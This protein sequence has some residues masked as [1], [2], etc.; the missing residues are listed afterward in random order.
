MEEQWRDII[1]EGQIIS[2][3][4]VSNRGEIVSTKYNEPRILK[5]GITLKGYAQ[6]SLRNGD[7]YQ[8]CLVHR[9][10]AEA[11]VPNPHK[12][13]LVDHIDTD[14]TNN[15]ANNLRWATNRTNMQNRKARKEGRTTSKFVGVHQVAKTG[16]WVAKVCFAYKNFNLG[17]FDTEEEAAAR[18]DQALIENG[19]EPANFPLQLN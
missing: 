5:P 14:H 12:L 13:P 17:T 19:F 8:K 10:V 9:L 18:Y 6:V 15:W 4:Q 1:I 11:F 7:K 16:R 3:Y 2:G